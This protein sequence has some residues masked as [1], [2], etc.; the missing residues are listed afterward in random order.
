MSDDLKMH[1]VKY[2]ATVT[3]YI[4]VEAESNTHAKV[5]ARGRLRRE[6]FPREPESVHHIDAITFVRMEDEE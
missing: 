4:Q 2:T 6:G 3:G 5:E 1:V